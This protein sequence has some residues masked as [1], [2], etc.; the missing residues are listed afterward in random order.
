MEKTEWL[1]LSETERIDQLSTWLNQLLELDRLVPISLE[2]LR[3]KRESEKTIS[4]VFEF[5]KDYE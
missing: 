4:K 5:V 1:L 3:E 2:K